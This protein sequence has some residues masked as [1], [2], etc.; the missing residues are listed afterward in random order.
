MA[1]EKKGGTRVPPEVNR[2]L[3]SYE[4]AIRQIREVTAVRVVADDRGTI[5]EIHVL[6]GRGRGP[7]QI[8]R[9]IESTLQAQFGIPVDHKKISIAQVDDGSPLSWGNGRVRLLGVRFSTDASSAEAEV[10]VEFDDVTHTGKAS[11]PASSVN[12]LRITAEAALLAVAEYFNSGHR[13]SLDDVMLI[14]VRTR[15]IALAVISLVVP[16]GEEVL[17]G[18]SLVR[19]SEADAVARSVLDAL[20]RRFSMIIKKPGAR[21]A[22]EDPADSENGPDT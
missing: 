19:T 13:L 12:R 14:E 10:K 11:G 5:D 21:R 17:I 22:S 1:G 4:D 20:N 18:T 6:A 16:G 9:D 7:K 8:V 2:D 15:K 3:R